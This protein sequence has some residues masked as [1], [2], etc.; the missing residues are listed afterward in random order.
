MNPVLLCLG[1]ATAAAWGVA[2]LVPTAKVAAGFGPISDDN[3]HIITM[4]IVSLF[5]GF[6][7]KFLPFRLCPTIFTISAGLILTGTYS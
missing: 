3:R 2:H 1:G 4:A 5:T 6:K 7:V